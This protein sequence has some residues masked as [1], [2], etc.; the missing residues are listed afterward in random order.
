MMPLVAGAS[1]HVPDNDAI[2]GW[3]LSYD[4]T[5]PFPSTYE[6]IL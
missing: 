5:C 6:T 1:C 4:M 3:C 2:I